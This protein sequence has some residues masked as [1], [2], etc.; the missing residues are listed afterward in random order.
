MY[1]GQGENLFLG[2]LKPNYA[3]SRDF[4]KLFTLF[5]QKFGS[6]SEKHQRKDYYVLLLL[7]RLEIEI[8]FLTC[9]HFENKMSEYDNNDIVPTVRI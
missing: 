4:D 7:P 5:N 8:E 9:L 3:V 2:K 1:G 6:L